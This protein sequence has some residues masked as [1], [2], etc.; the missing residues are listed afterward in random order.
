[1]LDFKFA[2]LL[3]WCFVL[4]FAVSGCGYSGP[5]DE[6]VLEYPALPL[7]H[8]AIGSLVPTAEWG[9]SESM[10]GLVCAL[11][12]GDRTQEQ[13]D[14]MMRDEALN[15]SKVSS[16]DEFV[17]LLTN[18]DASQR[19]SACAAYVAASA[20]IIPNSIEFELDLSKE[21]GTSKEA[22]SRRIDKVKTEQTLG[23]L[24]VV[25]RANA[26]VYALIARKLENK[27]WSSI[28]EY[29]E[30]AKLIFK[31]NAFF[32]LRRVNQLASER[33]GSIELLSLSGR[34]LEFITSSGY[35]FKLDSDGILLRLSG[36]PWLGSG[37]IL[38]RSYHLNVGYGS[39]SFPVAN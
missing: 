24:L 13:L 27:H 5:E 23:K 2:R 31:E 33:V 32:Y 16:R 22:E 38:G 7:I 3:T 1:M 19:T 4:I 20:T 18:K 25:A 30:Q 14:K 21:T 10:M 9:R 34:A 6:E 29:E 15:F 12:R 37:Y 36:I 35:R 17:S 26:E 28:S 39:Q 8:R 11:A